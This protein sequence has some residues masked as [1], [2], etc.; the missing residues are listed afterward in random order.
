[1]SSEVPGSGTRVVLPDS[2]TLKL[3]S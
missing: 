3:E 2:R 1:M